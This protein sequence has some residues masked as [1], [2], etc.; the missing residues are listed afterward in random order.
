MKRNRREDTIRSSSIHEGG[1]IMSL[2]KKEGRR[3]EGSKRQRIRKGGREHDTQEN[4]EN[5]APKSNGQKTTSS[6]P[7]KRTVVQRWTET[8]CTKDKDDDMILMHEIIGR[9]IVA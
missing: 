9:Y 6:R 7:R 3:H 8:V 1:R 2:I 4:K 5:I